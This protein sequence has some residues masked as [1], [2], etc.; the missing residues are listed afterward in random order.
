MASTCSC[1]TSHGASRRAG[2]R[3]PCSDRCGPDPPGGLVERDPEVDADDLCAGLAHR[4]EELAGADP[5]VDPRD[6]E[7]GHA[8]QDGRRVRHHVAAVG[9]L[10]QG[11]DPGVEQLQRTRAGLGLHAQEGDGERDDAAHQLGPQTG[12]AVHQGLGV[13][14]VLARP[15]LHEVAGQRVGRAGEADE[16]G[17]AQLADQLPHRLGHRRQRER[18]EVGQ[19]LDVGGGAH[20]A[21]EHRAGAGHDVD[22]DTGRAQRHDDVG[23][24]DGGVDA[25][26]PHRLQGDLGD[27]VGVRAGLEHR[28]PAPHLV[29]TPAASARPGA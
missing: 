20:R 1:T 18:V 16:R 28:D 13:L 29:G 22:V 23:V 24:E 25:V 27:Q 10:G 15:A 8:G 26:P 5:E 4:G 14:V 9:G 6:A 19:G 7:V 11:A 17:A 2:S 21:A 3:L 12:V